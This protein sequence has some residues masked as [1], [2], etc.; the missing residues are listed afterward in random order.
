M[1]MAALFLLA[2]LSGQGQGFNEIPAGQKYEVV[3][4]RKLHA[5]HKRDVQGKYPDLVQYGLEVNG[6]PMVLHLEKNEDLISENYT[7]T[8][9]LKDGSPVTTSPEIK[10][11]CFYQGYVKNANSS[12]VTLSACNGLSGIITTQENKFLIQPLKMSDTGA[13][14]VYEYQDQESPKTCGVDDK[15]VNETI[16][17][18]IDFSSSSQEKQAFL[19]SRKYIEMYI[20]ADNTMFRRFQGKKDNIRKRIFGIVNFVNQVYKPLNIFVALTGLEI[21]NNRNP[22]EVVSSAKTNLDRFTEWRKKQL[23]SRKPHDNAQFLTNIDFDGSTVGNAWTGG[24]CSSNHSAGVIQDHSTEYIP[25]AATLA[26]ELGHNLGMKHDDD[27]CKSCIMASISH[28][29]PRT[30]SSCSHQEYQNF[31]LERMPL[32][33]KDKPKMEEILSDPVCGNK[34]RERGEECD[35]GSE[36]ECTD[37]CC[38]AAT[39]KLKQGAQCSE[40][41]RCC[42]DC[43]LKSAGSVCR[44]AKDDCDL[45]DMCD[46]RSPACPDRVRMN[47]SPCKNGEGYCYNGKCP[48]FRSQCEM[49]WGAGSAAVEDSCYVRIKERCSKPGYRYGQCGSLYCSGGN[50]EPVN[51]M[52]GYCTVS[53]CKILDSVLVES[54]TKCGNGTMCINGQCAAIPIKAPDCAA[55]CPGNSVCDHELQCHC[56]E[57]WAPPNCDSKISNSFS[58]NIARVVIAIIIVI[59]ILIVVALVLYKRSQRK[60]QSRSVRAGSA[61]T[62]PIFDI[63]N[64]TPQKQTSYHNSQQYTGISM[65]PPRPPAQSQKPQAYQKPSSLPPPRPK[66]L[67]VL[68]KVS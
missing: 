54:G 26:H 45:S 46:G 36:E 38:D 42:S 34:F 5:H 66:H 64:Q 60:K 55:R 35:C 18:K 57:G 4:P 13:H 19:K 10:D 16:M 68:P 8:H 33:M 37:R 40:E 2:L 17:T 28:T 39:C 67:P 48:T 44:P 14:A 12:Q 62:S 49:Y 32:C 15:I 43:Q 63:Q 61:V 50:S 31:I 41:E 56:E 30:F 29:P 53:G 58:R 1:P 11:H 47:G 20:V 3:F 21:W 52:T 9:Y 22:F 24:M 65:H 6:Q 59:I 51:N 7:E 23:L 27:C 25:V